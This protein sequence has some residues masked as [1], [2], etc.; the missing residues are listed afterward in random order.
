MGYWMRYRTGTTLAL[1]AVTAT[2]LA[3]CSDGATAPEVAENVTALLSVEPA[4]GSVAVSVDAT[5]V[6]TFDHP[7]AE[8]MEE[9]A[10]LHEGT[11]A[12]PIVPGEWTRSADGLTLSFAPEAPLKP[13]TTYVIHVGGDMMDEDGH[14]VDLGIH[15][16]DMG[17]EWATP[18]MM[19]G[20]AGMGM[21]MGGQTGSHMGTGWQHPTN[22]SYGMVFTFTTAPA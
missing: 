3:A 1:T 20:G 22:G 4:A 9:Y 5:V 15:G 10:D 6:V 17:G 7:I 11:V 8:G 14:L 12:G 18:S 13:S 21:G 16:H 19:G 2:F